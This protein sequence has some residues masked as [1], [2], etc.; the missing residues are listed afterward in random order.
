MN[1]SLKRTI[2][3]SGFIVACVRAARAAGQ[4]ARRLTGA[5]RRGRI[6]RAYLKNHS[7]RK[8]QIGSSLTPFP[9]WLNTDLFPESSD[10]AYLDA[11]RPLPLPDASF[12]YVACE[13][14]I[15]HIEHESALAM[16]RECNRILKPGG[17]I[18][19]TT[20]DLQVLVRLC[21]PDPT[22]QQKNY[23][24]WIIASN[25]PGVD[26]HRGVFVLNNAFRAW[27]HQ[28]L[29]DADTLKTTLA[30][31]GFTDFEDWKPGESNDPNLRDI[32][33]HGKTCGN[34]EN[35]RYESMVVEARKP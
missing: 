17:K 25:L 13:H 14:M 20:P 32:E 9:D 10:V 24:D 27:G 28:F 8:L 23:I 33:L 7:L 22:P 3:K 6:I 30:R 5:M 16:L 26:Q 1:P 18:R 31:T 15:E 35:N 21:D 12:D 19:L 29:Y 2:K 34:E 4:D 11:T